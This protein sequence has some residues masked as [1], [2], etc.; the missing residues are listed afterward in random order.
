MDDSTDWH[1]TSTPQLGAFE[2][3]LRCQV[4]KKFYESPMITP[5][6]H[7]FCSYCIHQSITRD[8]G[9]CPLCR[10]AVDREKLRRNP[11]VTDL[12]RA[13]QSA[14][15]NLLGLARGSS[16]EL[17]QPTANNK[18][19]LA[20]E[21]GPQNLTYN[22]PRAA[23]LRSRKSIKTK[24]PES[25]ISEH[26]T[27]PANDGGKHAQIIP[28]PTHLSDY[29]EMETTNEGLVACPS[30]EA[31]VVENTINRHLD[32]CLGQKPKIKNMAFG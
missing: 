16:K 3:A 32:M 13:F 25:D 22:A 29:A 1:G 27:P 31:M 8:K 21:E 2:T 4:C 23:T 19:R 26:T 17:Q 6:L 20:E 28:P 9:I 12:V 18:K 15:P 10:S 5:C 24:S 7:T 30:C 11:I 14:R